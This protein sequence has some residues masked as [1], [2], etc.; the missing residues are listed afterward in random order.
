[1][2]LK[3]ETEVVA[4]LK[5][6]DVIL[7]QYGFR[8]KPEPAPGVYY[9]ESQYRAGL[10]V[11]AAN[12]AEAVAAFRCERDDRNPAA[13]YLVVGPDCIGHVRRATEIESPWARVVS[14]F[15]E[16][17]T[18]ALC[19]F[20]TRRVAGDC[21]AVSAEKTAHRFHATAPNVAA[22]RFAVGPDPLPVDAEILVIDADL[23][24]FFFRVRSTLSVSPAT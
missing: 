9:V 22:E 11:I 17:D 14:F 6:K 3:N 12:P 5:E 13:V 20:L 21:L 4:A 15:T 7:A 18:A 2:Q 19:D 24:P 16:D 23:R 1:M 8:A 10:P